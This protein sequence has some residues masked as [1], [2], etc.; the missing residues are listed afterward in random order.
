MGFQSGT[1]HE[2]YDE[3][4]RFTKV[5]QKILGTDFEVI[6]EG[7]PGRTCCTDDVNEVFGNKNGSLYFAQCVYSHMPVDYI[8]LMLGTNDLKTKYN[9]TVKECAYALKT[10]YIQ[11]VKDGL[12][13]KLAAIPQIVII[14]PAKI[15]GGWGIFEGADDKSQLFEKEYKQIASEY[16]CLFVSNEGLVNGVDKIH[17]TKE[18]HNLLA[19]KLA[20]IFKKV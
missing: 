13:G 3:N 14:A 16:D 11:P 4:A 19:K 2:R 5:L 8:V 20:N 18:S 6:E 17:L 7:L 10:K 1:D 9:K 15:D 12:D